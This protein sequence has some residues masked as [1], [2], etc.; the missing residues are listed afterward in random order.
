MWGRRSIPC[1][2]ARR[3]PWNRCSSLR[4]TLQG[5]VAVPTRLSGNREPAQKWT[6][7]ES[8][9]RILLGIG[10]L[11]LVF[12]SQARRAKGWGGPARTI[13]SQSTGSAAHIQLTVRTDSGQWW[14][15]PEYCTKE[16]TKF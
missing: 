12:L 3:G 13:L 8:F 9:A 1:P 10:F 5:W 15:W 6:D 4:R 2:T 11:K 16:Y 14:K 7:K